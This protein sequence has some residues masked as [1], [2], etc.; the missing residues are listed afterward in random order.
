MSLY[1]RIIGE[2]E[3]I[4]EIIGRVREAVKRYKHERKYGAGKATAAVSGAVGAIAPKTSAKSRA[5]D[6]AHRSAGGNI[7]YSG[8]T[9]HMQRAHGR[10]AAKA[11]CPAGHL[12][13]GKAC[14]KP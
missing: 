4:V 13:N 3:E 9:R 1:E 11:K 2:D 12:W 10:S 8:S 7:A 5:R 14:Y 6:I